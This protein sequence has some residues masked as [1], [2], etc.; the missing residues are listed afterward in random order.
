MRLQNETLPLKEALEIL[1]DA[2]LFSKKFLEQ[3]RVFL[4]DVVTDESAREVVN[5][6]LYLETEK[7]G[8]LI[9]LYI[10]SPGGSVTAGLI[11]CDTIRMIA[12]PVSTVCLGLAGSM[13]AI[14]LS[15][16]AKGQRYIFPSG[17]V[18]IHQPSIGGTLQG[19]AIDIE[20]QARQ[21]S[22]AKQLGA[23][24]LAENCGHPIEKILKDFDRDYWM[25]APEAIAY[26]IVDAVADGRCLGFGE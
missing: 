9:T 23:K 17:E 8:E 22:K 14:L 19:K 13:G 16:G 5:R 3:R 7:P 1:G 24:I 15:V 21:I 18:M 20:I 12:S 6:L 25:D 10:N 11:I 4:W 26:G 2:R